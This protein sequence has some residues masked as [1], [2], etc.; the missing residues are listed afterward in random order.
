[1]G[2]PVKMMFGRAEA[3]I[4]VPYRF[5]LVTSYRAFRILLL[6]RPW[7]VVQ[8]AFQADLGVKTGPLS[9]SRAS[10]K[11]DTCGNSFLLYQDSQEKCQHQ[12][13]ARALAPHYHPDDVWFD[14][15]DRSESRSDPHAMAG[16]TVAHRAW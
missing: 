14:F 15:W 2:T 4:E 10:L 12:G 8:K 16:W 9:S 1:M 13:F 7:L 5:L 11:K 6:V 3:A